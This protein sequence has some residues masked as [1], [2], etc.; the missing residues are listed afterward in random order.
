MKAD[1]FF[2]GPAKARR[3]ELAPPISRMRG[4]GRACLVGFRRC[5][6][7]PHRRLLLELSRRLLPG[8]AQHCRKGGRA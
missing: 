2:D 1:R 4:P 7:A 8:Y 6:R 5:L 3:G